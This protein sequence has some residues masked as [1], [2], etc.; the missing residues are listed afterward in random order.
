MLEAIQEREAIADLLLETAQEHRVEH[1]ELH[2]G[3][4][5]T[6]YLVRL[7]LRDSSV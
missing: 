1:Q 4:S 3:Y 5:L 6:H 2:P 7:G